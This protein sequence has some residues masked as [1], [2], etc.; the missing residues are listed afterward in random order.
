[1][2]IALTSNL[3][4]NKPRHCSAMRSAITGLCLYS[5][6]GNSQDCEASLLEKISETPALFPVSDQSHQSQTHQ[7]IKKVIVDRLRGIRIAYADNGSATLEHIRVLDL[8]NIRPHP[9]LNWK[10]SVNFDIPDVY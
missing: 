6:A 5:F 9:F 7:Q 8:F 3:A 1:M 2:F 10:A 4:K